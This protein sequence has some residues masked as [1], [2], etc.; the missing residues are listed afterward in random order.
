MIIQNLRSGRENE[1]LRLYEAVGW[2]A[3]LS[4]PERIKP[5]FD[6]SLCVLELCDEQDRLMGFVRAVGD[7]ETILHI[8]D[9]I[10]DPSIQNQGWGTL[11]LKTMSDRYPQV[12][13]KILLSDDVAETLRF[14]RRLG[15]QLVTEL[16]CQA[17]I[18][19]IR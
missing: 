14:Y 11:L 5:A 1:I 10:V 12:R 8:Q 6:H 18:K 13:Q 7:G 3:Y 17:L 4:Q 15:W 2:T 9:L 19:I 16:H